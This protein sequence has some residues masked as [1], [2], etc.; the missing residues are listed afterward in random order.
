MRKRK[1]DKRQT[2]LLK[3]RVNARFFSIQGFFRA[4]TTNDAIFTIEASSLSWRNNLFR[5][6]LADNSDDDDI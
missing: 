1:R 3:N 2:P 6:Q 5:K 4:T